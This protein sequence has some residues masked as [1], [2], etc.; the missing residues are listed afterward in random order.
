M[1]YSVIPILRGSDTPLLL[2]IHDYRAICPSTELRKVNTVCD[3][4]FTHYCIKCC[5]QFHGSGLI[6]TIKSFA[7][8]YA[9][10]VSASKLFASVKKS[11]IVNSFIKEIH[12]KHLGL[13]EEDIIVIP[14]F[15]TPEISEGVGTTDILPEDFILFV[16]ALT[17]AKGI[18]LLVDAYN[19]MHTNNTKLVLIG[20]KYPGQD[21]QSTGKI[22]IIENAPFDIVV[23][24][25]QRCRFAVFPSVWAEPFGIVAIEAMSYKKAVIATKIGGLAD[26]VVDR[27]TG[28]LVP[29]NNPK[30]LCEAMTYL[31]ENPEIAERM[32]Q[33]GYKR[34]KQN[35][36]AEVVVP[37]IEQVYESLI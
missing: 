4:P 28:M 37:K 29:P 7:I 36:A 8:Y 10:K 17:S 21:Y 20:A 14:N 30:A 34:W 6:G 15:C 19:R 22:S 27:E 26:I 18:E 23:E 2:T 24:A 9:T 25:Y 12:M 5:R 13:S 35:F 32:G 33:K 16:G 11:I 1:I 3:T 31:L